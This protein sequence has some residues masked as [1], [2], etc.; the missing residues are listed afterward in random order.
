MLEPVLYTEVQSLSWFQRSNFKYLSKERFALLKS[1]SEIPEKIEKTKDSRKMKSSDST[2]YQLDEE[3]IAKLNKPEVWVDLIQANPNCSY[4]IK[5]LQAFWKKQ[6]EFAA[7]SNDFLVKSLDTIEFSLRHIQKARK[8]FEQY[9]WRLPKDFARRYGESLQNTYDALIQKRQKIVNSMLCRLKISSL[10]GNLACEKRQNVDDALFYVTDHL[11][12]LCASDRKSLKAV[13]PRASLTEDHYIKFYDAVKK[14]GENDADKHR[15]DMFHWS[16]N[17]AAKATLL[18][19]S[20]FKKTK[21]KADKKT[22]MPQSGII[23]VKTGKDNNTQ[24]AVPRL[25]EDFIPPKRKSPAWYFW[26]EHKIL[27]FWEKRQSFLFKLH[28]SW[29]NNIDLNDPSSLLKLNEYQN[30]IHAE[31][32][33]LKNEN[34][35]IS[36]FA[37]ALKNM[38]GQWTSILNHLS[39]LADKQF[40]EAADQNHQRR[41]VD[42]LK[43]SQPIPIP[44][45]RNHRLQKSVISVQKPQDQTITSKLQKQTLAKNN[46]IKKAL[47]T[48]Q[49]QAESPDNNH[50]Q[51]FF[52]HW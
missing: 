18:S 25:L 10:Y 27:D 9:R 41:F 20:N 31:L 22:T 42:D 7:C 51:G 21:N 35:N 17:L 43:R 30:L 29:N 16:K 19:V 6:K 32:Q 37:Y 1:I 23:L 34:N 33:N 8:E 49:P 38:I 26:Q 48:E 3:W 39:I 46:E 14:Y 11:T 5:Q 40:K 36:I 13:S 4:Q 2:K 44:A 47:I 28:D 50:H 24:I 45:S 12:V 15:V 52:G